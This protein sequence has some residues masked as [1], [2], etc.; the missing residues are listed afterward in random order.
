[1]TKPVAGGAQIDGF[2]ATNRLSGMVRGE[3]TAQVTCQLPAI[4]G[5]GAAIVR[6][7]G[8]GVQLFVLSG[9]CRPQSPVLLPLWCMSEDPSGIQPSRFRAQSRAIRAWE[10]SLNSCDRTGVN[11]HMS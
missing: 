11:S 8:Q 4:R 9:A 2:T 7:C 5:I 10:G 1:V 6:Y 3:Y